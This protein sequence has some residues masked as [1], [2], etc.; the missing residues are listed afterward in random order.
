MGRHTMDRSMLSLVTKVTWLR[1]IWQERF[2]H[3]PIVHQKALS[4]K[5][6]VNVPSWNHAYIGDQPK[7]GHCRKQI[8]TRNSQVGSRAESATTVISVHRSEQVLQIRLRAWDDRR[9]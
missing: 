2:L 4:K 8:I 5:R 3:L 9:C 6:A 1:V 7:L